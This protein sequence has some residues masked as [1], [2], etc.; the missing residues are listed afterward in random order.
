MYQVIYKC[1]SCLRDES[2]VVGRLRWECK[3]CKSRL[4]L[5]TNRFIWRS[6]LII[7][8]LSIFIPIDFIPALIVI[9]LSVLICLPLFRY[10][11][12]KEEIIIDQRS[13]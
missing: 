6:N 4:R 12:L 11:Y 8:L 10:L 3:Q 1:P 9:I 13:K 5:K 7:L 2:V